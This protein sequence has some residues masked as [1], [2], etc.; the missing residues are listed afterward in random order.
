MNS[1]IR[2]RLSVMMFLEYV[3]WGAWLPLLGL[4]LGPEYLNF[5]GIHVAWIFNAFAIASLTG[6]FFGGQ[7][8]DRYF[9]QEKFLAFSHL[10]GGL[11]MLALAYQRQF[12]P[13]FGLM[14][15]HCFFYVPTLS[16]TNSISFANLKDA[17]KEFGL[18][19]LW[20]TIGWIAASWP[21]IFIPIDW[22]KVPSMDKAGGVVA[23][24]GTALSKESLKTGPGMMTAL[25]GTF[26]V[27][28]IASLA[29]AAFC[30]TLP[31]TPPAT[32]E[33]A[34]FAP[35]EAIR[36][37]AVPSIMILFIVTFF[38]AVV[39]ACYFFWTSSFLSAIGLAQN[40][41]Q[42][43]M[44][45]GQISEIPA[46]AALGFLLK[47]LGWRK[48]M[49]L[50]LLG[51]AVRFLIYSFG[52]PELLWLVIAS[53]LVHGFAYACFFATVYIFVDETFP[54]DARASAQGLFNLLILGVGPFL[55]NFLWGWLGKE[56]SHVAIVGGKEV[57]VVEFQRLFLVPMG[58]GLFAAAILALFFHPPE[59]KPAVA[60]DDFASSA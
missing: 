38:D 9:S 43:A 20:G 49:I 41:I 42:P 7:L 16:I 52:S 56:F 53:N 48:T 1:A 40:W 8:A 5:D 33:G 19:R 47:H 45:I 25:S 21:F 44:S 50:G 6:M 17:Q 24:L 31:R 2:T 11:S 36:L 32:N 15:L 12:W 37:L 55:G 29:L 18:V 3:I 35:F 60:A 14:M 4:Y 26:I 34:K 28:G 58:I 54:K 39:H 27:A 22:S 10:I 57:T 46:M 59:K 30:L 51:Q 23:W 13:F